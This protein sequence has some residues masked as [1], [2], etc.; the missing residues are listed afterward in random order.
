MGW[1]DEERWLDMRRTEIQTTSVERNSRGDKI[2]GKLD[3]REG[4]HG[5][6]TA[7]YERHLHSF[8][9]RRVLGVRARCA[10]GRKC[11]R[12]CFQGQESF[13][14]PTHA[15]CAF[16]LESARFRAMRCKITFRSRPP[17]S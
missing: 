9:G 11:M 6:V 15:A 10:V 1:E 2:P 13:S 5:Q 4:R 16:V 14:R 12:I 17:D 7:L 8:L 3:C